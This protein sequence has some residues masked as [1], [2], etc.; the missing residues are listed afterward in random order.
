M[1]VKFSSN[2]SLDGFKKREVGKGEG[3][4]GGTTFINHLLFCFSLVI[5][6]KRVKWAFGRPHNF[7]DFLKIAMDVYKINLGRSTK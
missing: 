2:E 3:R 4:L 7:V 5:Q 1:K 6:V